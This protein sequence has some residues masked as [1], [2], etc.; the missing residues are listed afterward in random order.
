LSSDS[1]AKWIRGY[2][3][4]SSNCLANVDFYYPLGFRH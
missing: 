1:G 2:E 4:L 3:K